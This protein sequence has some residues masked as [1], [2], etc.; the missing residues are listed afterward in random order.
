MSDLETVVAALRGGQVARLP[1]D[2]AY[3]IA[4]VPRR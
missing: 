2:A 4:V 1:T 3:S